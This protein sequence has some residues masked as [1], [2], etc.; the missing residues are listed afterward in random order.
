MRS[1]PFSSCRNRWSFG[2]RPAAAEEG[3]TRL[4][5]LVIQ[6]DRRPNGCT[7]TGYPLNRDRH[8]VYS[9]KPPFLSGHSH[10]PSIQ[11]PEFRFKGQ[12]IIRPRRFAPVS[13]YFPKALREPSPTPT[14]NT[15][16]RL[17]ARRL[18]MCLLTTS[19]SCGSGN[20]WMQARTRLQPPRSAGS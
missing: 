20:Q 4:R 7:R 15:R 3:Q 2:A 10:R 14:R 16:S 13:V 18:G 8:R 1:R 12:V 6:P 19:V 9:N 17:T 5:R 11:T